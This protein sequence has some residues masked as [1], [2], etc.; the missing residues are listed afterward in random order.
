MMIK[1]E[2]KN[3]LMLEDKL[4]LKSTSPN[5]ISYMINNVIICFYI[6]P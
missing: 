5:I 6:S 3:G 2:I 1:R 4:R